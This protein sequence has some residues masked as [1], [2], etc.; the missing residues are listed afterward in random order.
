MIYEDAVLTARRDTLYWKSVPNS[1]SSYIYDGPALDPAKKYVVK[2]EAFGS[3]YSPP[4]AYSEI[5]DVSM[6][7]KLETFWISS[8]TTTAAI[9]LNLD[10]LAAVLKSLSQL[11]QRLR[12]LSP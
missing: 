7:K 8:A 4:Y 12:Q 6:V 1:A 9:D 2:I 11:L 3:V 10:N 5:K